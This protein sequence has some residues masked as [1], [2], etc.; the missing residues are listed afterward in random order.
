MKENAFEVIKNDERFTI[1]TEML[2]ISGVGRS[3]A[4]EKDAFTFFAPID[5]AFSIFSGTALDILTSLA[6]KDIA[7]SILSQLLIPNS[8]LY[9]CDLRKK[10]SIR[11]MIGNELKIM[12]KSHILHL[13]EAHILMP[14]IAASNAVVFPIDKVLSPWQKSVSRK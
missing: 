9:A 2:K 14:G 6:G 4:I 11:T 13:E 10:D 3:M 7:K 8:Y 1:L 5:H 12:E